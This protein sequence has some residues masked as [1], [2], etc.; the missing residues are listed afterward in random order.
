MIVLGIESSC[1]ETAAAV[2]AV[3]EFVKSALHAAFLLDKHYLPYY[4]WSF[5]ALKDL[6]TLSFLHDPLSRLLLLDGTA[7]T[8][9][10]KEGLISDVCKAVTDA[11]V[12][13]G[14]SRFEGEAMD[15]HA[16]AVN[17]TITDHTLRNLHLLY[18]I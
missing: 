4:K 2:L 9:R 1:D 5:R 7:E 18:G 12:A 13:Q 14:L 16:R 17:D 15:G 3:G 8:V 11:V 6:P 10:E